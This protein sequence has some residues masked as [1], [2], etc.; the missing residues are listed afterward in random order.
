[1][2]KKISQNTSFV[3]GISDSLKS[4]KPG[5]FAFDNGIDFRS[6]PMQFTINPR[7]EQQ[8]GTLI[9]DLTMWA[10]LACNNLYFY[11]NTGNIYLKDSSDNWTIDHIVP[12]STGNGMVYFA[13]DNYL[14]Y[15]QNTTIGRRSDACTTG[16]YYDG[17]LE[18]EGGEP[19]NVK[20][21]TF[22][23]A[24][25]QYASIA[26]NT[27]LSITDDISLEAYIKHTTLPVSSAVQ[28]FMS[29]WNQNGNQR[30][31]KF[32]LTTSSAAFGDGRD[33]ALV[34]SSNTT[35]DPI[36]ANCT[37]TAG[38]NTLT[39]TNAH[40][41]FAS[42]ASG[43]K[44][45]VVQSRGTNAGTYQVVTVSSYSGGVVTLQENLTFSPAHSA[46]TTV[47]NKAQVRKIKQH[48]TVTINS[49]ITYT[50]KAWNGLKGGILYFWASTSFINNGTL[51]ATG[52][53]YN[54]NGL[55]NPVYSGLPGDGAAG[56]QGEGTAGL[57]TQPTNL[58]VSFA[59]ALPNGNGG[60]AG[61]D[62]QNIGGGGGGYAVHGTAVK[63]YGASTF[64]TQGGT[65]VG[66]SNLA[67][68]FFG[69]QG[70]G[71]GIGGGQA[72]VGFRSG[73]GG[74]GGGIIGFRA[75]TFTNNGSIVSNGSNGTSGTT[76]D[77]SGGGGGAGGSIIGYFVTGTLG[78]ITATGG[79]GGVVPRGTNGGAGA[80]GRAAFY[81]ATSYTGNGAPVATFILDTTLAA[82]SGYIIRLLISSNG[83]NSEIYTQDV[84]SII[85]T[86]KWIRWAVTWDAPTSTANFYANSSLLGTQQG[87]FTSIFNSTARFALATSY[88]GSGNPQEYLNAKM[89]DARV[90]NDIRT[91]SELTIYNDRVLT[92]VD[93]NLVAYYKF[94]NNVNDSQ[95]YTTGSNLTATNTPTYST[96]IPFSGV[97]SRI[98][99]DIT[100]NALGNTYTLGT[101][102]S[103]SAADRQ[104]F[105]PTK[106]PIKSIQLK[107]DTIGTGNWTV[108]IHDALNREVA[109]LTVTNAQLTLG[110]YEFIF[111]S[112][113]RP[114]LTA[115]YH[116]HVYSTVGDGKIVTS[117]LNNMEGTTGDTGA[118][119]NTF[120]QILVD[121]I[122][123][124]MTQF[125]NYVVIGNERYVAKLEAG[126][127]YN[128]HQLTLPAGY[129]VRC[130]AKWDEYL[131]IGV[132]KGDSITDTDQGKV[133]LWDGNSDT[134]GTSSPNT[135]VDVLEG[136]VNAMQGAAGVLSIIAGY[137]G[138]L[139]QYGG[140]QTIKVDQMPLLENN[141]Y[142]EIA[143]GA[144]CM[145]R[146]ILLFG[147]TLNT[148]S[149]N[150]HQGVYG[151][152]RLNV[153]YPNSLGFDFPLSL[154]DQQSS[155]VKVGCLFPTGQSLYVG[156]Q[157][158]N[159]YGIDKVSVTNDCYATAS[160]ELSLNDF[161]RMSQYKLP[162]VFRVDFE[163]LTSGQSV[164][165]KVKSEREFSWRIL[166]TE[167]TVGAT[168][169]RA[170]VHEQVKE[171]QFAI[172]IAST[173]G[174][175]P[176][177]IQAALDS[178]DQSDTIVA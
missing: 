33:G 141:K 82:S 164:T 40:A 15:A 158:G 173:S 133:F 83:T 107:I 50:A 39:V 71:A 52:K 76:P 92:G 122:Y 29:K 60:G 163:P 65:A 120:Y 102:L 117:S 37:G 148:D 174:V 46:T 42:V 165:I 61:I 129:R 145:W 139:L 111:A 127:I 21:I 143:P 57:G 156:W 36:D 115:N 56:G 24:S 123:H 161:R 1:M 134:S 93:A 7:T 48:T 6:D 121:D 19:T 43:D 154:G 91:P 98:D 176:V 99:Q 32:D 51:T 138:K 118:N 116:V 135:I 28:T 109:S 66:D 5:F 9:N 62:F 113:F 153:N 119:L 75:P 126:N 49:T 3:G 81:Y 169:V 72:V 124:P 69:G 41:S 86:G 53:G 132:W 149:E 2:S 23:S 131:A 63:H 88:D 155:A 45:L 167:D 96:D 47:A 13:E 34:I 31:Y 168:E 146:A 178:D 64:T 26:D 84:T 78:T 18:S 151:Y 112:S 30:S 137:D 97:T 172:D 20:S 105:A 103:E 44:L 8:A 144:M 79:T 27:T 17:F 150:V 25:S 95:T 142:C 94:E 157:K 73:T 4:N 87:S 58:Q 35:E 136:G 160:L 14:Y 159:V 74:A 128:P 70:G 106:E 175:S 125:E 147:A 177:I 11:G 104:T 170:I 89:D 55:N 77:G 152:G 108:V 22:A 130:F 67:T 54:Q 171:I 38:Q 114:I 101:S 59:G 12:S 162:L 16:I 110:F 85:Q 10:D 90:W 140:G 68:L 80:V 100:I 166:E